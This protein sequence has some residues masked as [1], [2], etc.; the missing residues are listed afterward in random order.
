MFGYFP[1]QGVS[2]HSPIFTVDV[3]WPHQRDLI[4]DSKLTHKLHYGK[5]AILDCH[6]W[7]S[8]YYTSLYCCLDSLAPIVL[9][10]RIQFA[11]IVSHNYMCILPMQDTIAFHGFNLRN[12]TWVLVAG[13]HDIRYTIFSLM[14]ENHT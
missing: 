3:S 14:R 2:C 9:T 12:F 6:P 7:Y 5:S 10:L 4:E 1:F 8:I 11:R 13:N